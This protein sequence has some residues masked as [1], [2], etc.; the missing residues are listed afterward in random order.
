MPMWLKFV[1]AALLGAASMIVFILC[2]SSMWHELSTVMMMAGLTFV[3]IVDEMY[4][5]IV[6]TQHDHAWDHK[7]RLR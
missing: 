7:A 5:A 3:F 6:A 2:S 4:D 1:W